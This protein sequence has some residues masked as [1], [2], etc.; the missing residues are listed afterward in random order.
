M[1]RGAKV[2]EAATILARK[3]KLFKDRR[4]FISTKGE[5]R[6]LEARW[7]S[8]ANKETLARIKEEAPAIAAELER[9]YEALEAA[10]K[11]GK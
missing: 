9:E 11:G 10:I 5:F 8:R 2:D 4:S 7:T 3:A 6:S 1:P